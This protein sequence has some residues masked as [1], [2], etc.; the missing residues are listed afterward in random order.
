MRTLTKD[1][2]QVFEREFLPD[3]EIEADSKI[4]DIR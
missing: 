4:A 3:E 2:F 1:T